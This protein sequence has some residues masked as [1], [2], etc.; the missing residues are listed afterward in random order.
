MQTTAMTRAHRGEP[1]IQLSDRASE[2]AR[3]SKSDNTQRAYKS[4]WAEFTRFCQMRSEQ[5]FPA[6]P[7]TV[8]NYLTWLADAGKRVATIESKLAAITFAHRACTIENP[9]QS[10]PVRILMQGIRR[11]VG[12]APTRKDPVTLAKLSQMIATLGSD[13]RGKRDRAILLVGYAGAFRRSELAGLNVEDVR[14]GVNDMVIA[15]RRSKTDQESKGALKHIPML[16]DVTVCPVRALEE[17]LDIAQITSGALF[18]SID[19]WG[20]AQRRRLDDKTVALTIKRAAKAAGFDA[21]QFSGHSLRAGFVTQ[22]ATDG[23]PE[24]A[25]AEVTG[26]KSRA[27]LQRYIRDAGRGQL[28]AIRRAFGE[29]DESPRDPS[30]PSE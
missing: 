25:I 13:L 18:R 27:V 21:W 11:K 29:I 4:A 12:C 24:W 30:L 3:A 5:S 17:W 23:V 14:F 10:E 26:H 28:T 7:A 22:A 20:H 2:Y 6:S 15:L 19:R 9:A 8:A 1:T 16:K